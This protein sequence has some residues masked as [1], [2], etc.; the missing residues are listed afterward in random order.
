MFRHWDGMAAGKCLTKWMANAV[1]LL[2][3]L[4]SYLITSGH[5]SHSY[6]TGGEPEERFMTESPT[7]CALDT[8]T[9]GGDSGFFSHVLS[10]TSL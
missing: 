8:W 6:T 5:I 10:L 4:G 7:V 9:Q 3:V 1:C 2:R